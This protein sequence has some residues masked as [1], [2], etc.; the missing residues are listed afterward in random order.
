MPHHLVRHFL[1]KRCDK[2]YAQKFQK[3]KKRFVILKLID[4]SGRNPIN[5]KKNYYNGSK[6]ESKESSPEEESSSEEA[7]I[8]FKKHLGIRR[9][10]FYFRNRL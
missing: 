7:R 5:Y 3:S 4:R 1:K 9:G 10:V 6:K 2:S 8:V